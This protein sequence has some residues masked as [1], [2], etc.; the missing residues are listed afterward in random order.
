LN[1]E[2][3]EKNLPASNSHPIEL[4]ELASTGK[5]GAAIFSGNPRLLD[6][7]KVRVTVQVGEIETTLGELLALK[8]A[9]VLK[10]NRLV[11]EP[12]DVLVDGNI[13]A[14]GQLVVVG[15][16]FGVRITDVAQQEPMK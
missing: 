8:E 11:D 2:E 4:A 16:N 13:I 1:Q 9:S 3:I 14:R 7:V 5:P 12:I 15:E 6:S 10:V